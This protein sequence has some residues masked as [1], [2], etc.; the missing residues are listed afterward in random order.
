MLLK[1]YIHQSSVLYM[2]YPLYCMP[3]EICIYRVCTTH[4]CSV[5]YSIVLVYILAFT[6]CCLGD[7]WWSVLSLSAVHPIACMPSDLVVL[8]CD[9]ACYSI[10]TALTLPRV[11]WY[12]CY[13]HCSGTYVHTYVQTH[14]HTV[15]CLSGFVRSDLR[16]NSLLHGQ[17]GSQCVLWQGSLSIYFL[18]SQYI[19]MCAHPQPHS[20]WWVSLVKY[21][22]TGGPRCKCPIKGAVSVGLLP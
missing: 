20:I 8:L 9:I 17:P 19:I 3:Q 7:G 21:C 14:V 1:W 22:K 15:W 10:I 16:I 2:W 12:D 18:P 11:S 4:W 5:T 13:A 6:F